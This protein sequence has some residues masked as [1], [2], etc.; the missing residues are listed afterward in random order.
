[1]RVMS[2][3]MGLG[4]LPV[5]VG[6]SD[7]GQVEATFPGVCP[8]LPDATLI[9]GLA[10]GQ[11][12]TSGQ[13]VTLRFS[14]KVFTCAD[15]SNE[16]SFADCRDWWSFNLTVPADFIAPGV[17][18]LSEIGTGFGDLI[19]YLHPESNQGCKQAHCDGRTEGIGSVSI[20]D[21]AATLEIYAAT[22]TCITGR[23][24]GLSD[25]DFKDAPDYN[26]E[27]FA[28]RCP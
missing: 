14:S 7:G 27:F 19:N 20:M 2:V 3:L 4:F 6:A 1:M 28:I 11:A 24:T 12:V 25:P 22:D 15:W 18:N 17:H 9:A 10:T 26:G 16:V 5:I 13:N 23:L 21:P 8:A